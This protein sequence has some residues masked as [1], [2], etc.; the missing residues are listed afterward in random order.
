MIT[1]LRSDAYPAVRPVVRSPAA[2]APTMTSDRMLVATAELAVRL[3]RL[4]PGVL[5][6]PVP[7]ALAR[8]V[9]DGPPPDP[10]ELAT[11]AARL[12]AEAAATP[13]TELPPSRRRYLDAALTALHCQARSLAGDR[14]GYLEE[15]RETF[16]VTP[17]RAEPDEY[18]EAHGRLDELLPGRGP[19]AGRMRAY[20]EADVVPPDRLD[21]A[22]TAVTA[23][24]R[25]GTRDRL[26]LPRG[27]Q[28]AVQVVGDRPWAAFTRYR[29]GLRSVV[30]IS[31]A[32][33]VRA[34]SLLPLLAHETYPGHHT[35]YCRAELAAARYPEL[36]LRLVHSPQGLIAEGA[37]EVA[38]SVV[39]GP[40][41]GAVAQ[42]ALAGAGV[43]IDGELAERI[44]SELDLLGRVR[45]DAALLR[46]VDGA[47]PDEVTRYLARWLL[48]PEDRARRILAFL[49]HP[50]W[51]GYPV[52]YAEGA[53]L[54]RDRLARHPGGPVAALRGLLDVPVLPADLV[55]GGG[56][57]PG[58]GSGTTAS[59]APGVLH[60]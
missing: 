55:T 45:Q 28:V 44:E 9:G 20:R 43:R 5:D 33:R 7:E 46:H 22:V 59:P 58:N 39:P 25:R 38:A 57:T 51:R 42:R 27:E 8:R 31:A 6:G 21:A 35:Q 52:T 47:G 54:V 53:P 3:D 1:T 34:G 16:G 24:L 36:A 13:T 37:A 30:S 14:P 19:V 56:D 29:G 60:P 18:R 17:R 49:D 15:V 26:G 40:G 32:A 12:R 41:W 2:Y 23:E 10:R 50:Q 48:V 11:T 4:R